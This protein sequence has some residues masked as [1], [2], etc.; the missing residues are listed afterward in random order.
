[1]RYREPIMQRGLTAAE[2]KALKL[3]YEQLNP[4]ADVTIQNEVDGSQLKMLIARLP[5]IPSSKMR[6]QNRGVFMAWT[7]R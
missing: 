6:D 2:A 5:H 4:G 7:G 3:R 1:M